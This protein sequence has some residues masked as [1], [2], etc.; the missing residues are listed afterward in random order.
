MTNRVITFRN[1]HRVTVLDEGTDIDGPYLRLRHE[2]PA[3]GRQAGPHWHPVLTEAWT[4]RQGALAFRIDGREITA[5]PGDTVRAAAR[6]VHEFRSEAPD[7]VLDHEIR[8]P[9]RHLEMFTLWS[10]LDRAGATTRSGVPRNPLALALLWEM[11]DGYLA[12]IPARLQRTVLGGLAAIARRTGYANR[13]T[14][15]ADSN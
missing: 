2:L 8:P 13:W 3:P 14:A 6:T 4:V 1:G 5:G 9:L 15:P 12:G 10:A 7:T 11:Q